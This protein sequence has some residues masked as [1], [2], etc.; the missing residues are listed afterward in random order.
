MPILSRYLPGSE[1]SDTY[2][3]QKYH[4]RKRAEEDL[5]VSEQNFHNSLES[6]L[7]GIRIRDSEDCILFINQAYLDIFCYKNIEEA[8]LTPD[9]SLHH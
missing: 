1:K 9:R 7:T 5:K 2:L 4:G 3:C 6:L 8:K